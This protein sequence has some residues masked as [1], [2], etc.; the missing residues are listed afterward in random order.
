MTNEELCASFSISFL[1]SSITDTH[2]RPWYNNPPSNDLEY[3]PAGYVSISLST[4]AKQESITW[5]STIL[6]QRMGCIV[7]RASCALISSTATAISACSKSTYT[8]GSFVINTD[9][10]AVFV[11]RASTTTL[12]LLGWYWISMHNLW[13]V[14][15]IVAVSYSTPSRWRNA[16]GTYG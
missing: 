6:C 10:G 11:L 14:P 9:E 16:S 2:K 15:T 4:L 1:N 5:A 12:A 7:N 3:S 13:L 8:L